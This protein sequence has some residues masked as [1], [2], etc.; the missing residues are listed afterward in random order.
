MSG[1]FVDPWTARYRSM[2]T[3]TWTG[4]EGEWRREEKERE[5]LAMVGRLAMEGR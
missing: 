4:E 3:A 1:R 2:A 5:R